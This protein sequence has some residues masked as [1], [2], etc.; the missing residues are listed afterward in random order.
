VS[1]LQYIA[2]RLEAGLAARNN[3]HL[4]DERKVIWSGN[5]D[6]SKVLSHTGF[7]VIKECLE[8]DLLSISKKAGYVTVLDNCLYY[9]YEKMY[10]WFSLP[11]YILLCTQ[12]YVPVHIAHTRYSMHIS[13][14]LWPLIYQRGCVTEFEVQRHYRTDGRSKVYGAWYR[15]PSFCSDKNR[16]RKGEARALPPQFRRPC[17]LLHSTCFSIASLY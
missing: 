17:I 1:K 6:Y 8:G 2:D 9:F 13:R 12:Y 11:L 4:V 10:V 3:G 14:H 15:L 16:T 5:G 7:C